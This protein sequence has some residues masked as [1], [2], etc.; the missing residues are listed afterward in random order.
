[1]PQLQ[2]SVA[3]ESYLKNVK[4]QLAEIKTTK[5]KNNLSRNVVKALK[6]LKNN[7]AINLKKA[8]KGTTT[9]IMNKV[10]KIYEANKG[11]T[12][13]QKALWASQSANGERLV[14][15]LADYTK[16]NILT[17]WL[18]NGFYKLP[19]RLEYQHSTHLQKSTNLNR[20]VDPSSRVVTA[21]VNEY[22][23]LWIHLSH[24][25]KNKIVY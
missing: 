7:P 14:T 5:P 8:D 15:S 2:Y 21:L 23:H 25:N 13:T 20:L 4:T 24:T 18:R 10:D 9:V 12:R 6:E 17:T 1:M 3:F 11:A 22:P 16:A 19:I